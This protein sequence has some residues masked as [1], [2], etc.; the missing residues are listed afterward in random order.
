M[1][2]VQPTTDQIRLLRGVN[3]FAHRTRAPDSRTRWSSS[4]RYETALKETRR[5]ASL[6]MLLMVST[7]VTRR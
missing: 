3:G 6:P 4:R 5:I 7:T 2:V 1:M